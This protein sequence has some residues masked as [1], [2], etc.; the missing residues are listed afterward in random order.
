MLTTTPSYTTSVAI[1]EQTTVQEAIGEMRTQTTL[2]RL[3]GA[4]PML[5][6]N[7]MLPQG[8]CKEAFF[9]FKR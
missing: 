1:D 9:G 8:L 2:D 4:T 5:F 6:D 7:I 3:L